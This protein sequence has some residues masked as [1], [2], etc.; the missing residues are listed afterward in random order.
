M[1]RFLKANEKLRK[2]F[3]YLPFGGGPRGCIGGNYAM[4]QILM[5]LSDVLRRYDFELTP[6]QT[7][8]ARPMVI[9][10]PK[11]GIRMSFTG[12]GAHRR[13][14]QQAPQV[15]TDLSCTAVEP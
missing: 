2:P 10:R 14:A 9:L 5:I 8:E 15:D 7:I 11:H 1:D 12:I 13:R 4:L 6:G 3:T